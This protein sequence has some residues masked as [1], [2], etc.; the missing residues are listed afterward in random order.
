AHGR[1]TDAPTDAP[2]TR[3]GRAHERQATFGYDRSGHSRVR[4]RGPQGG[5][6]VHPPSYD[7]PG[8]ELLRELGA[9]GMATV[10]LALQRSLERQ[11]A[12][13]V[14]RRSGA[15]ESLEKRFLLEG[16]TMAKLPHRNIV[17]VY[18]IVQTEAINYI[19]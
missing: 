11:V 12:I 17:G 19:A 3:H 4:R 18:D 5:S 13:K 10:F 7:I 1:A 14:M 9:G 16:R 6:A 15:D 2:R 8:Y